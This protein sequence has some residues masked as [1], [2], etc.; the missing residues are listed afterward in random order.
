ML[1][2]R[3]FLRLG[4]A[5][6][7]MAASA[8]L[9]RAADAG[10]DDIIGDARYWVSDGQTTL[11][12]VAWR[13]DLGIIEVSAAN[14]GVDPWV[15]GKDRLILLPTAHLVPDAARDGLVINKGELR[16]YYFPKDGP[17]ESHAIGLGRDGFATPEGSTRVVR[18]A[19]EPTWHP[20]ASSREEKPWLPSAVP[21]GPDNP[22]GHFALYLG[23][24]AY[25][26][27]GTNKPYGVGRF[28][29]HGCIRMYPEAIEDLFRRVGVGARVTVVNQQVKV[30]W[31]G[32]ELYL[33]V[34]PD[35]EQQHELETTYRMTPKPAPDATSMIRQK[36][37][38]EAGRIDWNTVQ[39]ELVA[40]RGVPVKI[41]A[42]RQEVAVED[43]A[44]QPPRLATDPLTGLY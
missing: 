36:A 2:R 17:P 20:T 4:A 38:A 40:C 33:Q 30:G 27:H 39:A 25:L 11:L 15:P 14:Q 13:N 8:R 26:I 21:P 35:L 12:D 7:G 41:T 32:G 37:G 16:L 29:S 42:S 6:L 19:K 10:R 9:A 34:H 24:P 18:K 43:P 5:A 23:W 44:L 22:L 31:R 1:Q 28:V 3:C